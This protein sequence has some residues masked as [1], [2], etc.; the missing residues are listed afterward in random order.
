M[1]NKCNN[2][3]KN[4]NNKLEINNNNELQINKYENN[5]EQ[6]SDLFSN[7]LDLN[8]FENILENAENV[9]KA[10]FTKIK[11]T[12]IYIETFS[13]ENNESTKELNEIQSKI[14]SLF[15]N[16]LKIEQNFIFLAKTLYISCIRINNNKDYRIKQYMQILNVINK[17]FGEEETEKF[18]NSINTEREKYMTIYNGLTQDEINLLE[19]NINYIFK[20]IDEN[21]SDFDKT[22]NFIKNNIEYSSIIKK[23]IRIE[24]EKNPNNCIDIDKTINVENINKDFNSK[25]NSNLV[26]S[27]LGKCIENNGIE[28]SISKNQEKKFKNIELASIQSLF[29]LGNQKKYELHFDFGEEQNK[30]ILE[31]PEKKEEFLIEWKTKIAEKLNIKMENIILTEVHHGCVGVYASLINPSKK[32]EDAMLSLGDS[33]FI[34]KVERKPMLEA[35]QINSVILDPLGDRNKGW[36]INETRGGEKYIPPLGWYGIGIKVLNKY[37]NGNNAWLDY[38]NREGEFAIA[39]LGINNYLNSRSK[40]I[41]DLNNYTTNINNYLSEKLYQEEQDLKH[42]SF[43]WTNKCGEGICLF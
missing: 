12:L 13:K 37:D 36:G 22:K 27:L 10:K 32:D 21:I 24:K 29:S 15:Y 19:E 17:Y 41:E 42:W 3:K 9:K 2:K 43:F 30:N 6:V 26:L 40:I 34:Q 14:L 35:L 33:T 7:F 38:R 4:Y 20:P 23:Y 39:Y 25:D 16:D 31:N 28:I 8:E 11:N 18:N 1:D 5:K